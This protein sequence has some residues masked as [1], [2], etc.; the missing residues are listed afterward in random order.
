MLVFVHGWGLDSALWSPLLTQLDLPA[1]TFDLGHLAP[2]QTPALPP[3]F[4][5]IGHSFGALWLLHTMPHRLAGFIAI[6]GFARFPE[7]PGWPGVPARPL[8]RMRAAFPQRPA[9]I[10]NEFRARC[11]LPA[12]A[13]PADPAP[14][15]DGLTALAT[16]DAR[17]TLSTLQVPTLVLAA[18]DD[19]IVPPALAA[20]T[21]A[22]AAAPLH[23]TETGGHILPLTQPAWCARHIRAFAA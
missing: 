16:W 3:T 17:A 22:L 13:A 15:A 18:S 19:P 6:A 7:A 5:G 23:V 11:A 1:T 4:I 14:L 10:L 21:A 2:A 8:H 12:I 20:A 9:E